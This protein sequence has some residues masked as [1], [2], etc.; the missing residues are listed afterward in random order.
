M[1][2]N[3]YLEFIQMRVVL[4]GAVALMEDGEGDILD[5]LGNNAKAID[6]LESV[7][8]ALYTAFHAVEDLIKLETQRLEKEKQ[9]RLQ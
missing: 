2:I 7:G 6:D 9:R 1:H 8:Y 5:L 3:Y 4:A